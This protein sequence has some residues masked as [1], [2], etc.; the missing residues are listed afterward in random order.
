M[1]VLVLGMKEEGPSLPESWRP[2]C[3]AALVRLGCSVDVIMF[4]QLTAEALLER[5]V[6]ADLVLWLKD[7]PKGSPERVVE[8]LRE[9]ESRGVVT[10]GVHLDLFHGIPRRQEQVGRLPWWRCQFVFTPDGG[11]RDWGVVNH[12]WFPPPFGTRFMRRVRRPD[13]V[14][15]SFKAA[16][17]GAPVKRLHGS[18]RFAL[19]EWARRT[20]GDRFLE[21]GSGGRKAW[22]WELNRLYGSVP[23]VVSD[24]A[25]APRYWSDRIPRTL[26]RGGIMAHP[27][28]PGMDEWGLTDEVL[29][30]YPR[31]EFEV[32]R[33]RRES[34]TLREVRAMREAAVEVTRRLHSWD[35][36]LVRLF[37]EVGLA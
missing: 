16:F 5:S 10:A 30:R 9:V 32:I 29:I 8:A 13:P 34:M 14:Y 36:A 4:G 19:L 6:G 1:R 18:H 27:L 22:G 28:V 11:P 7:D 37:G 15:R 20:Y 3:L 21:T 33:E 26:G 31:G 12:R 25:W 17:V 2:D 23:L 24:S 35:A